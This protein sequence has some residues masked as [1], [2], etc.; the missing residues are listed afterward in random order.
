MLGDDD[1]LNGDNEELPASA[2]SPD[3]Q[4]AAPPEPS[5]PPEQAPAAPADEITEDEKGE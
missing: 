5:S 3:T 1:A 2:L 4:P